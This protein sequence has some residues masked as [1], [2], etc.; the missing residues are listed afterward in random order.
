MSPVSLHVACWSQ[1]CLVCHALWLMHKR[2]NCAARWAPSPVHHGCMKAWTVQHW[3][4]AGAWLVS[5]R[6]NCA[7]HQAPS[8]QPTSSRAADPALGST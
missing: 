2:T 3:C 4:M 1:A 5:A 8:L 7:A 6:T